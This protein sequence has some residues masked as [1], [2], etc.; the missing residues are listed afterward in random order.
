[1]EGIY[2]ARLLP[3][4]SATIAVTSLSGGKFTLTANVTDAGDAVSG[5]TVSAKG[6]S[7]TTNAI[8]SAKLTVSGSE[9]R[10]R[11]R[12]HHPS[13]LSQPQDERQALNWR[14][15]LV[16]GLLIAARV[17]RMINRATGATGESD[18]GAAFTP[19]G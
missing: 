5:A 8:G 12:H 4:L 16:P 10:P 19:R 15:A 3:E 2:Y 18:F 9:G 11:Q 13:R 14:G 7:K 17:G 6:Q 1:M